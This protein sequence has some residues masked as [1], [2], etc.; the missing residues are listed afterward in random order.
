MASGGAMPGV[1]YGG[2]ALGVSAGWVRRGCGERCSGRG[3]K[4]QGSQEQMWWG[5]MGRVWAR[6][7]AD[8]TERGNQRGT[9]RWVRQVG[10]LEPE[11]VQ[12][13]VQGVSQCIA[14][15]LWV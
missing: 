3:G 15:T 14:K 7:S 4:G 13:E 9:G 10:D 8:G 6:T 5:P 2:G 11:E 1:A 12:S